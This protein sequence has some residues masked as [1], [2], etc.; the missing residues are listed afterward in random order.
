MDETQ[1]RR[2]STQMIR[3]Q[4]HRRVANPR[5]AQWFDRD[6]RRDSEAGGFR[7]GP[8]VYERLRQEERR[9]VGY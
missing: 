1:L 2:L 4:G 6:R 9:A 5:F 3:L 8:G 7:A